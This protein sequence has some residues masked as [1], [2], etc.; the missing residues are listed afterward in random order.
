MSVRTIQLPNQSRCAGCLSTIFLPSGKLLD[1]YTEVTV[2]CP[3]CDR[4]WLYSC[5]QE[6]LKVQQEVFQDKAQG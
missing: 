3:H 1:R 4:S 6:G 5:S 2:T